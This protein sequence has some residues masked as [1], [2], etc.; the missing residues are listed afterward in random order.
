M[1]LQRFSDGKIIVLGAELGGGGE[2]KIY[3]VNGETSLVAKVYHQEKN[4][5]TE[6]LRAM[7]AHPPQDPC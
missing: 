6:K 1:Q 2:G 7:Y 5:N 4:T 3:E